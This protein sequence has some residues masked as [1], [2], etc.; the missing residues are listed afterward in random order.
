LEG[1]LKYRGNVLSGI[2]NGIDTSEWNPTTDPHIALNYDANSW[3]QGKAVCKAALQNEFRF[4]PSP[5]TPL[6]GVIGRLV[7]QKGWSLI[8][9]VLRQ[10]LE[11]IDAQWI[12]LG[13]GN[14]EYQSALQTLRRQYS[15][16]LALELSFSNQLAHR[17]E[18]A[19]DI[20]LMPSQYEP[21]G[22]SQMYSLA[23]G[24]VPV[25]RHTGGLA[26]TVV[27]TTKE[28]FSDGSATGFSFVPFTA[29]AME[30]TLARAVWTYLENRPAW[31]RIVTAG[32]QQDCSWSTSARKYERL[33][34]QTIARKLNT[35]TVHG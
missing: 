30:S 14:L 34:E 1:V 2:L 11:S 28:S 4:V 27:N 10:W 3:Q 32:M 22:L 12:V 5:N 25:V 17:I 35:A 29:E 21:C 23:Y 15:D 18:S 33:Y 19:A 26:D 24:T 6:I 20:F 9:P 16:K 8:L 7:A 13:Q 31:N